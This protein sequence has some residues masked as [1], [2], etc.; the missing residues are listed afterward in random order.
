MKVSN[1]TKKLEFSLLFLVF[2]EN[3]SWYLD[4]N[5]KAYSAH[6]EKVN[7][8]DD[9]FIESNKMHGRGHYSKTRVPPF[10]LGFLQLE[11]GWDYSFVTFRVNYFLLIL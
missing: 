2:D 7:K 10:T 6:P 1:P 11:L 9:E 3:E 4:D 5:I 8:E